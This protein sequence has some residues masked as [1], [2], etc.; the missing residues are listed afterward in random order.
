[1]QPRWIKSMYDYYLNLPQKT[2]VQVM[3]ARKINLQWIKLVQAKA[4]CCFDSYNQTS[5]N[6]LQVSL[7]IVVEQKCFPFLAWSNIGKVIYLA[8]PFLNDG[9]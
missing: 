1:M 2:Q 5:T 9:E 8:C 3:T 4:I 7:L 6:L